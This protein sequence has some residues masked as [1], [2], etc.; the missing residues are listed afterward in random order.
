MK[1]RNFLEEKGFQGDK[2]CVIT[3][4][5]DGYSAKK[6]NVLLVCYIPFSWKKEGDRLSHK[7]VSG[8]D[9]NKNQE[10]TNIPPSLY[11][12]EAVPFFEVALWLKQCLEEEEIKHIIG[13]NAHKFMRPFLEKLMGTIPEKLEF[14]D[15]YLLSQAWL[16]DRML[17]HQNEETLVSFQS[18]LANLSYPRQPS[19]S[20]DSLI[21]RFEVREKEYRDCYMNPQFKARQTAALFRALC[22]RELR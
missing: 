10:Y 2:S 16:H 19:C 20:L 12:Q 3:L 1:I 6:A 18:A 8:G 5:T 21:D 7:L 14:L 22:A 15:T 11:F 9:V 4:A 13:H 17:Q